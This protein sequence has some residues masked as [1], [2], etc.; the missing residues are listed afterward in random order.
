MRDVGV[1]EFLS[2]YVRWALGGI[3]DW[4]EWCVPKHAR[5]RKSTKGGEFQKRTQ[6][7]SV[8][9]FHP[10]LHPHHP[11]VYARTGEEDEYD[12]SDDS[13]HSNYSGDEWGEWV[14]RES[15]KFREKDCQRQIIP[16]EGEGDGIGPIEGDDVSHDNEIYDYKVI[17][18][19]GEL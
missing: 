19:Y 9:S 15:G 10:H 6:K 1:F 7:K 13:D 5:K 2:S 12:D 14:S 3:R 4:C 17:V 16:K 18:T 8:R 11:W